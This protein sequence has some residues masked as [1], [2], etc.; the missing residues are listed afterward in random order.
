MDDE[1]GLIRSRRAPKQGTPSEFVLLKLVTVLSFL[2]CASLNVWPCPALLLIGIPAL[3]DFWLTKNKEGLE[4]VGMRWS[5]EIGEN[6][7]PSW[8][9]YSRRDPYVPEAV[10]SRVFWSGTFLS[11]TLWALL[12][13]VSAF[14]WRWFW[15]FVC[16][17]LL[18][19]EVANAL[20]FRR[21]D[22]VSVQQI[23][24]VARS[25]MLGDAFD[26]D[27]LEP[28]PEIDL[29]AERQKQAEEEDVNEQP[30]LVLPKHPGKP[31]SDSEKEND[32]V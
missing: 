18:A 9:F 2:L 5:H 3:A 25:V 30:R 4:L 31:K 10:A 21:C 15:T 27:D 16:T 1:P 28:E 13:F 26:S 19:T 24:D 14:L 32:V 6:G 12:F 7:T 22:T 29:E 20:C 23:E 11:C 17:I 8:V